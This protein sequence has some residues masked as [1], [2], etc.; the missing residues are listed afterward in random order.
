M[1]TIAPNMKKQ[2]RTAQVLWTAFVLMFFFLQAILWTVAITMTA[3][4]KS[5]TVVAGY[6]EQALQ[7]D[8][9]KQLRAASKRLGWKSDLKIDSASDIHGDRVVTLCLNDE[10]ETPIK[11][12]AIQVKAYHRGRAAEKQ[13]LDLKAVAPGVYS[14]TVRVQNSG[15][16]QF[17]G[18][19]TV[20][21]NQYL[22]DQ[23]IRLKSNRNL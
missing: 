6:D 21:E 15:Q 2:E 8:E 9:V 22:I 5:H 3:G 16:W 1:T 20:G 23:R 18:T 17:T 4:D 14:G 7:W 11:G 10:I 12:A 19:A 13:M